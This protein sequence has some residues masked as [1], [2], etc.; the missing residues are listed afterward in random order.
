MPQSVFEVAVFGAFGPGQL[1]VLW[2]DERRPPHAA[3]EAMI[4]EAWERC[5]RKAEQSGALL[6]N[7]PLGRYLRHRVEAGRLVVE[8]GPTDYAD[9]MGTNYCNW[10]RGG[11]FGWEL[12]SNPIGTTATLI[13][14]D[15]WLL[16]GRR[17]RRV[18][19]LAGYIH[20]FGGCLEPDER[21][22]D[23]TFD[24]FESVLRELKEEL[25]LAAADVTRMVCLGLIRDATIRQPELIFDTHVRQSRGQIEALLR[26]DDP[27]AEH[28]AIVALRDEPA[29]AVPFIRSA[30]RIAPVAVGAICLHGRRSFGEAWYAQV[31]EALTGITPHLRY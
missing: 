1:A 15:G 9:W 13:T 4:A 2:R 26:P 20:T 31:L 17:S 27:H 18:A 23:G 12:Y 6:F 24:V 19:C 11:E 25:D 10:P 30:D 16:Y 5:R 21:R 22:A 14:S 3:L 29:A 8:V 28:D 7:G